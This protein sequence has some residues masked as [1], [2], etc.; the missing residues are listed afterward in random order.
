MIE[1]ATP[2]DL[3]L[4]VLTYSMTDEIAGSHALGMT[5]NFYYP[6]L[7][8]F[9]FSFTQHFVHTTLFSSVPPLAI[10]GDQPLSLTIFN[11]TQP[12]QH[13]KPNLALIRTLSNIITQN[14]ISTYFFSYVLVTGS[15]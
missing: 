3:H 13:L 10:R 6:T 8:W 15:K 2:I 9:C 12:H 5:I 7:E 11:L 4:I 14:N 1:I